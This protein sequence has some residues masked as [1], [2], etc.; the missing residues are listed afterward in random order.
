[1]KL[2]HNC[3]LLLAVFSAIAT[4]LSIAVHANTQ[5]PAPTRASPSTDPNQRLGDFRIATFN[6][7]LNRDRQ[8]GL[9]EDLEAN[10]LNP[11]IA[12]VAEIIQRVRP[13]VLLINEFDYDASGASIEAFQRRY[14]R[15]PQNGA[16]PID[17][18]W[19]FHAPSNTGVDT[20]VD[21][22][23]DGKI[24]GAGDAFGFGRFAGQYGMLLLSR[25]P[26]QFSKVRTFQN[27]LWRDMPGAKLPVRPDATDSHWYSDDALAVFRLSSK[28]H[29]DIPV[30]INDATVHVLASHP[31]PPVFDGPED[32]NGLRNH[33][34]I[35]F[36]ADYV[37]NADYLYDDKNHTGGLTPSQRFV[38]VGDLNA[39]ADEGDSSAN[40][41]MLIASHPAINFSFK[42]Q[43][44]GG[45]ENRTGNS[46]AATHT[47]SWGMRAD[48]VLPSAHGFN[49]RQGAVF[50]PAS[51]DP[52][53]RLTSHR[54]VISSDHRLV[55][56]DLTITPMKQ[57]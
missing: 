57:P 4:A 29:W 41:M 47:A 53:H 36:W 9:R 33:D 3:M 25:Y 55:W 46:F 50:W 11:Q 13:D 40:P 21:L 7:Y 38:I 19:L 24:G 48:Y 54:D 8:G 2:I 5:S 6:A 26:V 18:P 42:P 20:G 51:D 39:S 37:S 22:N 31:T 12:A 45:I 56:L 23:N 27:F 17:Y 32:R 15:A 34:E 1:M 28:S 49:I 14:L 16:T 43:S 10:T 35:R 30:Q 52:L 44:A